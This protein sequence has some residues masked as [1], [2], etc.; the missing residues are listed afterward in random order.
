MPLRRPL[1]RSVV[2][3][4]GASGGIG[5]ATALALAAEGTAVVL[6]ARRPD[7]LRT[8]ADRCVAAGGRALAV[9]TDVTDPAAVTALA[10][11]ARDR[12]GRIDAWV[13]NAGVGLYAALADAQL[14]EVRRVLD[15]NL[16]GYLYGVQAALPE[17]RA[18]GG[19]VIVNV[20]S[21]L[22]DVT[23]PFMGAYNITKHA[24]RGLSDTLRQELADQPIS[25]CTVLPASIDTPFYRNAA[26]RSGREI[27]PMPPVY[28]PETVARTVVRVL[29][30]PR[31]EAYAGGLGHAL[32]VQ[33]R[34]APVPVERVLAWYGRR[35]ALTATP[36]APTPGNLF[37]PGGRP[38]DVDGGFHGRSRAVLRAVAGSAAASVGVVALVAAHLRSK[39]R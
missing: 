28:P 23:V 16:L 6:A 39:R 17:L 38:G 36:A 25:V 33:W 24:V 14:D 32:A 27:R 8:V 10:A 4:T 22:S 11:A 5:A 31:R 2:V 26:N 18:A 3:V 30:R 1:A 37:E 29:R 34:L 9:P 35:A 21:V 19:G 15:V 13:N 12:F 7:A 20:A